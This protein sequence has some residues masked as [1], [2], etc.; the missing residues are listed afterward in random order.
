MLHVVRRNNRLRALQAGL[1][2][3][4]TAL[5]YFAFLTTNIELQKTFQEAA[6]LGCDT[7]HRT[8]R[9][10]KGRKCLHSATASRVSQGTA[11]AGDVT[12]ERYVTID[13]RGF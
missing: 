6:A 7:R 12:K 1:R 10:P 13:A 9:A 4:D 8:T 3:V 11:Q 5:R 2:Q